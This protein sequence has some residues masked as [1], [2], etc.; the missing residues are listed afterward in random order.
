ML[1]RAYLIARRTQM[2]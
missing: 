2:I 1:E